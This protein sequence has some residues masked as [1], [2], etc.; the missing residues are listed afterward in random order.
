[1][2]SKSSVKSCCPSGSVAPCGVGAKSKVY[3]KCGEGWSCVITKLEGPD[4]SFKPFYNCIEGSCVCITDEGGAV[5]SERGA[6]CV[7][8]EGY[9]CTITKTKGSD[10]GKVLCECGNGYS[11]QIDDAQTTLKL[12]PA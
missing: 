2:E 11:C 9:A 1:M 3:C 10:A 5:E 8:G 12:A 6:Y 7:C 4:D